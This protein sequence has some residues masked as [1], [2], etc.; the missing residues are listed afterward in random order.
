MQHYQNVHGIFGFYGRSMNMGLTVANQQ[1][2]SMMQK[3]AK[4]QAPT[5][6]GIMY[7]N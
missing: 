1:K 6:K 2:I 5:A 3:G 7:G 4:S